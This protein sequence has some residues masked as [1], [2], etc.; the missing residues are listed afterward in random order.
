MSDRMVNILGS[1]AGGIGITVGFVS[2]VYG[3]DLALRLAG[4]ILLMGGGYLAGNII[5]NRLL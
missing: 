4:F 1:F 2:F 5:A 3:D